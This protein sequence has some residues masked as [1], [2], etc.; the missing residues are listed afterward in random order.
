MSSNS[1][2]DQIIELYSY[3]ISIS[4]KDSIEIKRKIF[5][6]NFPDLT[7]QEFNIFINDLYTKNEDKKL[8]QEKENVKE[9]LKKC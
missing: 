1:T 8:N 4:D 3:T 5:Y 6:N 9:M 7:T 2:L